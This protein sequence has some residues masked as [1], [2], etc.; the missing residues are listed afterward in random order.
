MQTFETG[1]IY[2]I[3]EAAGEFVAS[4][5]VVFEESTYSRYDGA[6]IHRF[7]AGAELKSYI[8]Y[9]A[10][11]LRKIGEASPLVD[12]VDHDDLSRT[13][14]ILAGEI[15]QREATLAV[16]TRRAARSA[17]VTVLPRLL[18]E[19]TE[20]PLRALA[21]LACANDH[22]EVL[23]LLLDAGLDAN[24][25]TAYG[26]PLLTFAVH[27]GGA[28]LVA[29]LLQAGA[30]PDAQDDRGRSPRHFAARHGDPEVLALLK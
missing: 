8:D 18:A 19:A 30:D 21:L 28:P 20:P 10:P 11:G 12:A 9:V 25:T 17:R 23:R 3:D 16:V 24:A 29:L 13:Q 15:P 26:Q 14:A 4:E 2:R 5:V 7:F 6:W 27:K 1:A 22:A